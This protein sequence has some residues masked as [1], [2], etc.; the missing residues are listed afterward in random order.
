VTVVAVSLV[1]ALVVV[2][3]AFVSLARWQ[4]RQHARERELLLNQIMHLSGRT[5]TP[6]PSENWSGAK[7]GEPLVHEWTATPEQRPYA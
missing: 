3:S 2:T 7:D 1:A 5:W 6:P 4:M